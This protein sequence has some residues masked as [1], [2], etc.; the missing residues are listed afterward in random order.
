MSTRKDSRVTCRWKGR[1]QQINDICLANKWHFLRFPQWIWRVQFK[2]EM[3]CIWKKWLL[4]GNWL[5]WAEFWRWQQCKGVKHNE[6]SASCGEITAWYCISNL[7]LATC[8]KMM[9]LELHTVVPPVFSKQFQQSKQSD[10]I[11]DHVW[12]ICPHDRGQ[13][14]DWICFP[15]T[16][17]KKN[18]TAG[19]SSPFADTFTH[20]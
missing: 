8:R 7:V 16:I 12:R 17:F 18:G 19:T 11:S 5:N 9:H 4:L 2:N 10:Q 20:F 6:I 15:H 14:S 3:S 13:M 1:D